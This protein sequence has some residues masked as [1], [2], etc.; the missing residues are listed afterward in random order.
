MARIPDS[1]FQ[2]AFTVTAWIYLLSVNKGNDNGVV[3][4]GTSGTTDKALHMGER[5]AGIYFGFFGDDLST[6][7]GI[8][9]TNK[10]LV[11]MLHY[12]F[13]VYLHSDRYHVAWTSSGT[14]F[15]RSA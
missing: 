3:G 13:E 14:G 8:I 7:T 15:A 6:P 12:L 4:H 1:F 10:W 9:S 2:G 11:V 5:S